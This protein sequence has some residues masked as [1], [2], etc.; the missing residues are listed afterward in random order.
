MLQAQS[1]SMN[2]II[3]SYNSEIMLKMWISRAL[4]EGEKT[5]TK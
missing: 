3:K 1:Y 4:L 5:E 2:K